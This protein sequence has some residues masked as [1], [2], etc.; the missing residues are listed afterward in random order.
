M[1]PENNTPFQPGDHIFAFLRDSGHEKQEESVPQQERFL[2]EWSLEN[3]ITRYLKDE[4]QKGS[5][6]V[7]RDALHEL[8]N[9]LRHG[10][11]EKG[12]I[13]WK[14]NRFARDIDDA[15]YFR[16]EIRQPGL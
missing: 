10:C 15:P 13:I 4:A 5:S 3:G 9:E 16:G 8:M 1:P 14:Y 6:S 11:Q 2:R 12:V 7:G